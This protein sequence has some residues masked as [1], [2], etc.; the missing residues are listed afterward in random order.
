MKKTP[1]KYHTKNYGHFVFCLNV[2]IVLNEI[3]YTLASHA[4]LVSIRDEFHTIYL[5]SFV[6]VFIINKLM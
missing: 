5:I 6:N 2:S 4:I 3:T 1:L